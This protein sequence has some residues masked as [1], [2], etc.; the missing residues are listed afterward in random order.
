MNRLPSALVSI[1]LVAGVASGQEKTTEKPRRGPVPLKLQ[2]VYARYL[3]EKKVS[4]T[5]YTL[6]VNADNRPTRLRMGIEVPIQVATKDGVA[7]IQYKNVGN[8]LDCFAEAVDEDRFKVMC[9]FEQSAVYA[10]DAE[11]RGSGSAGGWSPIRT[12]WSCG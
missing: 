4:S 5:P 8:N 9:T 3:G 12:S 2:I 1:L 10:A 7:Q 6:S 11:R